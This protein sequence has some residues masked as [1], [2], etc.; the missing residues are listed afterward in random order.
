MVLASGSTSVQVSVRAVE[1]GAAYNVGAGAIKKIGNPISGVDGVTNAADWI[2]QEGRDDERDDLLRRRGFLA[3]EEI[4][5]GTRDAAYLVWVLDAGATDAFVR[6]NEP[7]GP[8]TVDIYILGPDGMPTGELV[9][10]VQAYIDSKRPSETSTG[11]I[12]VR[13]PV[14][15]PIDIGMTVT[16]KAGFSTQVLE[17]EIANRL[18]A[19][20]NPR[21][22]ENYPAVPS[23]GVGGDV[24]VNR[25][26]NIIMAVPGVYNVDLVSPTSDVEVADNQ[27]A[28]LQSLSVSFGEAAP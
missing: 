3:W 17:A 23:L 10:A 26:I 20:F 8:G 13:K 15:K 6:S 22:D 9:A 12:L 28:V 16:P 5:R 27:L 4:A 21:G 19:H 18:D 7:R 2:T 14:A 11:D 1:K 25:I 24:L